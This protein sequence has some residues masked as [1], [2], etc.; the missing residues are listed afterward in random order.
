[1]DEKEKEAVK[2][3]L[4]DLIEAAALCDKVGI[5]LDEATGRI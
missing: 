1:M 4:L 3:A 2:E 5:T